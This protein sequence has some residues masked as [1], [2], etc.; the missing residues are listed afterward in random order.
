M[1]AFLFVPLLAATWIV[2]MADLSQAA[3]YFLAILEASATPTARDF[4]WRGPSFKAWMR[5]GIDWPDQAFA[6]HLATAA[7][8]AFSARVRGRPTISLGRLV[9]GTSPWASVIAGVAFW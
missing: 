8:C 9:A 6:D 4:S 7:S 5:D 3:A 2:G 1:N